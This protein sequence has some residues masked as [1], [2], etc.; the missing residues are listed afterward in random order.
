MWKTE[1]FMK[2]LHKKQKAREHIIPF[3]IYFLCVCLYWIF[4][5]II[6]GCISFY[7]AFSLWK[8]RSSYGN[9][10]SLLK[11]YV[12]VDNSR[13]GRVP[14]ETSI[15]LLHSPFRINLRQTCYKWNLHSVL[16]L[17]LLA[18]VT[19]YF[20]RM[21]MRLFFQRNVQFLDAVILFGR[22]WISDEC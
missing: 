10:S 1:Y 14:R 13:E 22:H 6:D 16:L 15:L 2:T 12:S 18:D 3:R 5:H 19:K 4:F 7:I 8:R 20:C 21:I 17:Q 9:S 11:V